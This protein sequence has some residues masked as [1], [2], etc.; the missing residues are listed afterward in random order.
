MKVGERGT[1]GGFKSKI[2]YS[3]VKIEAGFKI[4][5]VQYCQFETPSDL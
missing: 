2:A 3:K 4:D 5:G 1:F